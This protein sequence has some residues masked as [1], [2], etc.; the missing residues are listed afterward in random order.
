[1]TFVRQRPWGPE[2][3]APLFL[4]KVSRVQFVATSMGLERIALRNVG[5]C[6]L[7]AEGKPVEAASLSP[8][9]CA[10]IGQQILLLCVRRSVTLPS[11]VETY[12]SGSF[13]AAD[14]LGIVG[15]SI[16]TWKLRQ[17]LAIIGA[18]SGHV[19]LLGPSGCGKELSARGLHAL[20][21]RSQRPLV[22]R[23]A[24]TIP[25][26]LV[27]V[28]LFGH[29]KGYPSHGMP[30]RLG[31]VG[32]ADGSTLFL[33]EIGEVPLPAQAHLLRL[34]D[35][36]EYHRLGES[37]A[38]TA[39]LRIIAATNREPSQLKSDLL[40]RFPYRIE[41]PGLEARREDIPLLARHLLR[42]LSAVDPLLEGA[43]EGTSLG[44][45]VGRPPETS[46]SLCRQLVEHAYTGH[47]RELERL[48]LQSFVDAGGGDLRKLRAVTEVP[49][50]PAAE[51]DDSDD[52]PPVLASLAPARIQAVLDAH[53][54]HIE[55]AARALGLKNRF[56]LGRLISKYGLEVRRRRSSRPKARPGS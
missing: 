19:L 14:G 20:S 3:V 7:F 46:I 15:E 11:P 27:D 50:G 43:A 17:E 34:L 24:A 12:P 16:A 51:A 9:Q 8:G 23:N 25:E 55:S 30:E 13:G 2:A 22:A 38:R 6:T 37:I 36:G 56:A 45:T 21:A 47:F 54:G 35:G 31:L 32:E 49:A 29:A 5:R 18:R 28:E 41:I 4:P 33:D 42:H 26:S 48:L 52:T 53:N 10:Q 39:D 40:A 44:E 1:L